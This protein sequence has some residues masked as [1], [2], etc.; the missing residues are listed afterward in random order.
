MDQSND[1]VTLRQQ[2]HRLT[3]QRLMVLEV[4][5]SNGRHLT[6]EEIHAAVLSHQPYVNIATIYRTLQ[7][8]QEVG[9]V[10]P[11]ALGSGPL[12]YEYV[13]GAIHHHLICQRCGHIEDLDGCLIEPDVLARL[14]R[15]V[16][17]SHRFNVTEH[18]LRFFGV[19]RR[20]SGDG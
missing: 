20:C 17:Q 5:K 14:R 19:C 2:G 4:I 12:H 7:W 3:P 11:I 16:R 6:A 13:S 10:V 9:L 8:L 18:E 15:R 1:A